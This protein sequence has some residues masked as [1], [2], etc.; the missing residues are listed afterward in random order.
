[1]ESAGQ[2]GTARRFH[3]GDRVTGTVIALGFDRIFVDIGAGADA[4]VERAELVD[5]SGQLRTEVGQPLRAIVVDPE[6]A[7]GPHLA[8]TLGAG[9]T[10]LDSMR[11]ALEAS[12]PVEGVVKAANKGGLE[13]LIGG[14]RAFCPA[15][16]VE[17]ARAEDLESYVGRKL[18][19]KVTEV[20]GHSVVVSRRALLEEERSAEQSARLA[21]LEVGAEVTGTVTSVQRYGAFVDLGGVEG[22]VH[23]SQLANH[24]VDRVE[25]VV[26][27]GD[28][29]TVR[30]LAIEDGPD[31][32]RVSLSIR[33]L[34]APSGPPAT[35]EVLTARVTELFPSGVLVETPK[36][37][38]MVPKRELVLSPGADHRRAYPVGTELR[39][40]LERADERSGRLTFSMKRVAD[41]EERSNF[42]EY[43]GRS[44]PAESRA[45]GTFGAL[46]AKKLGIEEPTAP[47]EKSDAPAP[48]QQPAK[49]PAE[50]TP[51]GR[52]KTPHQA[53][54]PAGVIR[55]KKR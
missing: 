26:T 7:D 34:A 4:W 6:H 48:A 11:E 36:G 18:R 33:A 31:G 50:R 46:L 25:D 2:T 14:T 29:V 39:V 16:Q 52:S 45:V 27:P 22:L 21:T 41:A 9:S 32:P 37:S 12:L 13:I 17:I 44:S 54:P 53:A 20:R 8:V 3:R 51:P 30:V 28:S 49:G 10:D 43:S 24:R 55:R 23:V 47:R 42:A 15:S 38:G 5:D 19:L 40:V 1:M 35:T